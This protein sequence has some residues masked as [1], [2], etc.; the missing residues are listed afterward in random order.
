M[1]CVYTR[2]RKEDNIM[3]S[4]GIKLGIFGTVSVAVVAVAGALFTSKT[5]SSLDSYAVTGATM[6]FDN[7]VSSSESEIVVAPQ[8]NRGIYCKIINPAES[9]SGIGSLKN[10]SQIKFY[11]SDLETE[12]IFE[13]VDIITINKDTTGF[14]FSINYLYSNGA[15]GSFSYGTSSTSYKK[16]ERSINFSGSAY[17]D[18]TNLTLNC[19]NVDSIV[20]ELT[21]ISL[22][23]NCNTKY[24]TGISILVG[25]EKINYLV[26]ESFDP[27]GMVV[28]ANYSNGT[29]EAINTF[30]YSPQTAFDSVGEKEITIYNHGFSATQVVNVTDEAVSDT[31]FSGV[32]SVTYSTSVYKL[33]FNKN[34]FGVLTKESTS[35]SVKT[36]HISFVFSYN[37]STRALSLTIDENTRRDQITSNYT[38]GYFITDSYGGIQYT[39]N[40]GKVNVAKT[41]I[42]IIM[43][44]ISSSSA[45]VFSKV[46]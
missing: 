10:G 44:G 6:V 12:Y 24:Q 31:R 2:T 19:Q 1:D 22:K 34:G 41:E 13:D 32:Y 15:S 33:T 4:K 28:R 30:T 45:V 14:A 46:S 5:A 37:T 21:S 42:N 23:Y 11:E 18:V 35:S 8:T 9:G 39:N 27:S 43:Y 16:A 20:S 36:S 26:G 7:V 40:T 3:L 29:N 38:S 17:G 25:P